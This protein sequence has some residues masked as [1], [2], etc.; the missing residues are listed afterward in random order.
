MLRSICI[1]VIILCLTLTGC[2]GKAPS[3]S[4]APDLPAESEELETS[5]EE[6]VIRATVTVNT[7]STLAIRKSPG[8]QDKPADDVVDRVPEG[9]VFI[10]RDRHEDQE[11]RDGYTW[12][13]IEDSI[14]GKTGWSAAKFLRI[15][16]GN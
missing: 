3:K 12:W 6:T 13:E 10:I 14:T 11:V 15:E 2:S 7:G 16:E 9:R 1:S 4:V 8:T 5:A